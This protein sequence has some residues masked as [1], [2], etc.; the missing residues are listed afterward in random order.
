MPSQSLW[1][2]CKGFFLISLPL[3]VLVFIVLRF[4]FKKGFNHKFSK[5]LRKFDFWGYLLLLLFEG[6][7]QQFA[8]YLVFEWENVFFFDFSNKIMKTFAILFGFLVLMVSTGFFF[9]TYVVYKRLNRYF[10]DNNINQFKGQLMLILQFGLKNFCFGILHSSTR[11]LSYKLG[12]T[13]IL[14]GELLFML[15]LAKMI[16]QNIYKS[17]LR[18]LAF[19]L[20][21]IVKIVL[22]FTFYA[23]YG[24]LNSPSIEAAQEYTIKALIFAYLFG[25]IV[26]SSYSLKEFI[27]FLKFLFDTNQVDPSDSEKKKSQ[28]SKVNMNSILP[29]TL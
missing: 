4:A 9:M 27:A 19:F 23:D 20:Q 3:T 26:E 29:P 16:T 18:I 24:S 14:G 1:G 10:M 21:N 13:I 12:L 11:S 25:F 28:V 5:L 6:N 8:F 2:N 15:L 22:I 17:R 7:I